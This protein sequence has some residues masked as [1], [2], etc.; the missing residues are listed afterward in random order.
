MK[1]IIII[2][3]AITII[4]IVNQKE[5]V[6]IPKESI[7]FRIIANSN[8]LDD[9]LLKTKI[10]K[11]IEDNFLPNIQTTN[12]QI[13]KEEITNNLPKLNQ[14]ISKYNIKYDINFGNNYFPQKE[15]KGITYPEGNYESLVITLGQGIGNNFWC[16]LYPPLCLIEPTND[17]SNIEYKSLV[18][19]TLKKLN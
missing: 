16:V 13:T 8:N 5:E 15:Y 18:L 19:E 7:R 1:K 14:L 6:I 10:T 12:Y 3:F 9:Q 17:L 11:D 2:L 4:F